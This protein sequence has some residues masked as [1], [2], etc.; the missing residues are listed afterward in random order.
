MNAEFFSRPAGYLLLLGML[1]VCV[2]A[3]I[4]WQRS[5]RQSVL[6]PAAEKAVAALPRVFTREG[7]RFVPPTATP[8]AMQ[9]PVAQNSGLPAADVAPA[10]L[11]LRI[12]S[13]DA[14]PSVTPR[15][16]IGTTIPCETVLVLESSRQATPLVALVTDDVWVDG[17]C[18]VAAGTEVHGRFSFDR[19]RDRLSADGSWTLVPPA[20]TR[21]RTMLTLHGTALEREHRAGVARLGA[22]G[23]RGHV[24]RTDNAAELKLFASTFLSTATLA[25]QEMRGTSGPLG[26]SSLPATTARNATLAGTSAVLRDYAQQLR[27]SIARDGSY[28]RVPAGTPFFLYVTAAPP[29]S[30]EN[31]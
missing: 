24:I 11:P 12:W 30:H 22:A 15:L 1:V 16:R 20:R 4:W 14:P 17:V 23:L 28:V 19:S 18:V 9:A 3:G 31:N 6:T 7:A 25:L 13:G 21:D 10:P 26:D 2:A 27:E 5:R 29:T 8:S